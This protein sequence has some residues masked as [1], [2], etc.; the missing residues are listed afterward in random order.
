MPAHS[1]HVIIGKRTEQMQEE[2]ARGGEVPYPA[3]GDRRL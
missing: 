2:L 3:T 1:T